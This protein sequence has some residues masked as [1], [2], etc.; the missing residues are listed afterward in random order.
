ME[1]LLSKKSTLSS[2]LKQRMKNYEFRFLASTI[3][4]YFIAFLFLHVIYL[5]WLLFYFI[6]EGLTE[7]HFLVKW[8]PCIKTVIII[9]IIIIIIIVI[10]IIIIIVIIIIM[11]SWYLIIGQSCMDEVDIMEI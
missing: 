8:A 6:L 5:W 11:H 1:I 9:I 3:N 7:Y 10:T 4:F 2:F